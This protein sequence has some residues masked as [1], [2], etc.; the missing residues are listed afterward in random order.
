LQTQNGNLF[1][2]ATIRIALIAV[3]SALA[4]GTD[5]AMTPFPNVKLMDTLVFVA[6]FL[7]GLRV[8]V[9]VG[10]VTWLV[11]GSFNPFGPISLILMFQILGETFYAISGSLL[12]RTRFSNVI[13]GKQVLGPDSA[14]AYFPVR[15]ILGAIGLT[16]ALAYDVL[17]NTATWFIQL[18]D[19]TKN[20]GSIVSQSLMVGLLTMNFPWPFGILHQASDC[21]FFA[22]IAPVVIKATSKLGWVS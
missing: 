20:L 8:G 13:L 16:G 14:R 1:E 15:R 7:F 17:T 21:L 4:L 6:A 2:T 11:Y 10:V 9:G 19:P 18:Y 22:L 5:Y 3:F 12:R